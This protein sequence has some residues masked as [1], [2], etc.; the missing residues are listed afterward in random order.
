MGSIL[1]KCEQV[2]LAEG[3]GG[4]CCQIAARVSESLWHTTSA[5]WYCA[6]LPGLAASAASDGELI[7][8]DSTE[9]TINWM[10]QLKDYFSFAY[11]E[12]EIQ[13]AREFNHIY[14]LARLENRNAGYIKIAFKKVYVSDFERRIE[15]PPDIAFVYDTFVHPD[16]RGRHLAHR[17]V[18][19]SKAEA[20]RRGCRQM[21]CHI[22]RWNVRSIRSFTANGFEPRGFIR[23]VR[24]LR[25][26][27][28][29]G[30]PEALMSAAQ[31]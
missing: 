26:Q 3:L 27:F 22:P 25:W 5:D 18:A 10:A 24:L 29:T 1:Q 4:C 28:N 21:W 12:R 31:S 14:G 11:V 13:A 2:W 15:L 30:R 7:T 17:L 9:S 20:F 6:S 16:F 23:N 8:F 19:A